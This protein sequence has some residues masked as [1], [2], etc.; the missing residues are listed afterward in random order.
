MLAEQLCRYQLSCRIAGAGWG[1][2]AQLS[3]GSLPPHLSHPPPT[4]G[5]AREAQGSK[6][7]YVWPLET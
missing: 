4:A 3:Q 6:W 2:L 1:Q 5:L 7:K